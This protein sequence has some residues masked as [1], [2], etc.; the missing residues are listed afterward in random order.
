MSRS[1]R[2]EAVGINTEKDCVMKKGVI[3]IVMKCCVSGHSELI[4]PVAEVFVIV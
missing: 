1:K 2:V 4:I 3:C